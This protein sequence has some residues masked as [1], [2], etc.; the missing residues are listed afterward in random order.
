VRSYTHEPLAEMGVF[1]NLCGKVTSFW[2]GVGR[3]IMFMTY[4]TLIMYNV[5]FLAVDLGFFILLKY[6]KFWLKVAD[7]ITCSLCAKGTRRELKRNLEAE[8]AKAESYPEWVEVAAELD[9]LNGNALWRSTA[10]GT[11]YDFEI[12]RRTINQLRE[13][14]E[15]GDVS[16]LFF[17]L[18]T[19]LSRSF[20]GLNNKDLFSNSNLGTKHL[21]EEFV[22][23]VGKSLH[24]LADNVPYNDVDGA[25]V[26][27]FFYHLN[28]S[29]GR[30][31]L[32]LSG[33]GSLTMYHMGIIKCL[34]EQGCMPSVISGTSGGSIVAGICAMH[35][36]E[37]LIKK[38]I[39]PDICDRFGEDVRFFE[40]FTKQLSNFLT[41]GYLADPEA[42]KHCVKTYFGE[43]TFGEAYEVTH[44][45]VN[46]SVSTRTS[47]GSRPLLL[48]YL[49]SPSVLIW[50]AVTASC[51][52]P[53]LIASQ[54]L[55][56]KNKRGEQVPYSPGHVYADGSI[57]ADLPMQRLAE[58]FNVN[59]FIVAQVN[60]HV[61]PFI[62][63]HT[64]PGR[65]KSDTAIRQIEYMLNIDVQQRMRKLAKLGLIPR[66]YG[67]DIAPVF[68]QRY[69]GNVTIT[70]NLSLFDNFRAIQ[71][72][73]YMDMKRYIAF[74]QKAAWPRLPIIKHAM[75]I[76]TMLRKCSVK[77]PYMLGPR[78]SVA[79]AHSRRMQEAIDHAK[80]R[81]SNDE[82]DGSRSPKSGSPDSTNGSYSPPESQTLIAESDDDGDAFPSSPTPTPGMAK[83]TKGIDFDR[84]SPW[85]KA[86]QADENTSFMKKRSLSHNSLSSLHKDSRQE[87]KLW[88]RG[89]SNGS[90]ERKFF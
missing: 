61:N 35:T 12:V 49:S 2:G 29:Y 64:R 13:L 58:L 79:L 39:K 90:G 50:S 73:T 67:N 41:T 62:R 89:G 53:G 78:A 69:V 75:E 10:E 40:P 71:Q 11:E 68:M 55:M 15:E 18:R 45:V 74:G 52:L 21:V 51:A 65:D 30:C 37:V 84:R 17:S 59:Y 81:G 24:Y 48:N 34:I 44:R 33:G 20:A 46:I 4:S 22:E 9:E 14:R 88:Y 85:A 86:M 87:E 32:C 83:R 3:V 80:R 66:V 47:N 28:Q 57:Q 23:E 76:E 25:Q 54:Q 27:K 82:A 43:V 5:V 56:A 19:C 63:A 38:Y 70:P 72:P 1:K 7:R 42:F 26:T 60:P 77:W 36:D 8:L 31:A 16:D 6:I